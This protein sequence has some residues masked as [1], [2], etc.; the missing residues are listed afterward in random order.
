MI[1][2]ARMSLSGTLGAYLFGHSPFDAA[3]L[4]RLG[5][6]TGEFVAIVQ[7]SASDAE[8]LAALRER[9]FD[10]ALVR[11]WSARLPQSARLYTTLWDIDDGYARPNL[12]GRALLAPWRVVERP[13]MGLLRIIFK[14]P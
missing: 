11:R 9:G 1:D 6:T 4:K 14:A 2:K 3:L 13:V 12:M 10:E 8:V 5:T 7:R